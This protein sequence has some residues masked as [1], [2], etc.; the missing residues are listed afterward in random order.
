MDYE[1]TSAQINLQQ[2]ILKFCSEEIQPFSRSLDESPRDEVGSLMRN[3]LKKL[4]KAGFM[5]LG[6][7][8]GYGG[9]GLDLLS[10]C[11]AGEELAKSC[12][13]TFISAWSSDLAGFLLQVSGT[14][15]QKEKYLPWLSKGDYIGALAYTESNAGVDIAAITTR[16]KRKDDRWILNGAKVLITNAPIADLFLV[17]AYVEDGAGQA[18]DSAVFI[19]DKGAEGLK[20][21][22]PVDVMGLRGSPI[23]G[24]VMENCAIPG[25]S[26]LG[27][28][29]GKGFE[30][31]ENLMAI[32]KLGMAVMSVGI[33]MACMEN[34]T[35]YARERKAFGEAIGK[36]QDV[37]FRLA[38]MFAHND[39]GRML[40]HRAAWG[41][42]EKDPE[43]DVLIACAKL[44]SSEAVSKTAHAATQIFAGHGYVK[45][46]DIERLY[47][48]AR[49][50]EIGCGTSEIQRSVIARSVLNRYKS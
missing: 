11:V 23:S 10:R 3:N 45:G 34:A 46:T 1:L 48:D 39:L 18:S 19:I 44:F 36:Y 38:E 43:T 29:A 49:F 50:C 27:G 17:L 2:D 9:K 47:R 35:R 37:S 22:S 4:G 12:A 28:I 31:I 6:I 15:E 33:G 7:E 25:S 26:V 16:A 14:A 8:T 32:G 21:E 41:M 13:S 24:I 5:G 30:Q 40:I 42:L 20:I